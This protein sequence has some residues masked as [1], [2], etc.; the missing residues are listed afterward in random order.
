MEECVMTR[1]K[2]VPCTA[3]E[4]MFFARYKNECGLQIHW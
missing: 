2:S 1:E 4:R 3:L